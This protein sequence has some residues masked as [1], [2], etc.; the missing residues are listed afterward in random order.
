MRFKDFEYDS[1]PGPGF[2]K[3]KGFADEAIEKATKF[4]KN[5]YQYNSPN[6]NNMD[7]ANEKINQIKLNENEEKVKENY[8]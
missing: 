1:I 6:K 8:Y 4:S 2:Y 7:L 5:Q 3:L